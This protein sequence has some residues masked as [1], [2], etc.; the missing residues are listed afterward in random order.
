MSTGNKQGD[1]TREFLFFLEFDIPYSK[2]EK[3]GT[4]CAERFFPFPNKVS[5]N[6]YKGLFL[7][8]ALL[9]SGIKK[10]AGQTS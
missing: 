3:L 7:I 2:R 8:I 4:V 6:L 9:S 1:M 10:K 5:I